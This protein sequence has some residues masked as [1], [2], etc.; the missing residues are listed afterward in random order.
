MI[1][2]DLKTA[3]ARLRAAEA[4]RILTHGH[5]DGDTLGSAFALAHALRALKKPVTVLCEDP[6]PA[7]FAY[8]RADVAYEILGE[9]NQ[10]PPD[11]GANRQPAA[12][13]LISVDVA[14]ENLLGPA[15]LSRFGGQVRLNIDHHATNT[16]F[17][18]ETL[19]DPSAAATAEIVSDLIDLMGVRMDTLMA[20]CLYAGVS[21]DT[22]CFRYYNTTARSHRYAARY[23]ELGVET[24]P[25]DRA[26]FETESRSYMAL[27]RLAF[28]GLRYFAEGRIALIA[29]TQAM[30]AQSGSNDEEYIKLVARTRQIEG[31]QVGVALRER[32]DGT[33][34]ISLRS[35]ETVD[36]AAICARMGGGGHSRA[37]GCASEL[38]LEDTIRRVVGFVE[39]AIKGVQGC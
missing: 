15:A 37:A 5:P 34:K 12:G 17:A 20:A 31:V 36:A 26:F 7:M 11:D 28:D 35:H 13:F 33:Y 30:F 27:E 22:G 32:R 1:F 8:M 29:V 10:D 19:L 38:P 3:A 4:V 9:K 2:I 14:D 16:L 24:E 39:E 23:M 18:A 21:T 25:L 6:I